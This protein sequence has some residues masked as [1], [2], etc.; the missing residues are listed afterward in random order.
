[1]SGRLALLYMNRGDGWQCLTPHENDQAALESLSIDWGMDSIGDQPD[2]PV[3]R[4]S[5]RD[6]TGDLAGDALSLAGAKVWVQKTDPP[7]WRTLDMSVPWR[8]ATPSMTW[9]ELEDMKPPAI[10]DAP[11]EALETVFYGRVTVGGD[12]TQRPADW[13]VSLYA[14]GMQTLAQRQAAQGSELDGQLAGHHWPTDPAERL[15]VVQARLS[16]SGAPVFSPDAMTWIARHL[17]P[18]LAPYADDSHPDLITVARNL[19]AQSPDRPTLYERFARALPDAFDVAL[20]GSTAWIALL[21]DGSLAVS[22]RGRTSRTLEAATVMVDKTTLALPDPV[23]QITVKGRK[24]TW[25]ADKSLFGFEDAETVMSDQGLVPT[26]LTETQKSLTVDT[27]A[28]LR[29]DTNG[30]WPHGVWEPT[31][32]DRVQ[33]ATMILVNATRLRP[34]S[35]R[36]DSRHVDDMDHADAFRPSPGDPLAFVHNRYTPLVSRDGTPATA[37]AWLAIGGTLTYRHIA[38]EAA[39]TNEV[40]L[41]P[42]PRDPSLSPLRWDDLEPLT[43]RWERVAPMTWAELAQINLISTD[44]KELN[45]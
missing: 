24:V 4:F 22:Y 6:R 30:V 1:M 5:I 13:L 45:A 34:K 11:D 15:N 14:S 32:T 26:N 12:I 28:V 23:T 38:G 18:V 16:D 44:E 43:C 25:D 21:P 31:E 3:L 37:G 10:P 42:L 8:Q 2:A 40:E 35:L 39:W 17:P 33:A 19:A 36:I 27:D 41:Q 20:P 9:D 29:D 7:A